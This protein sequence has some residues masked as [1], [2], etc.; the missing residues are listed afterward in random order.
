[1]HGIDPTLEL[2]V[3]G[4]AEPFAEARRDVAAPGAWHALAD[5]SDVQADHRA[6]PLGDDLG[7][8]FVG[9][10]RGDEQLHVHVL[11]RRGSHDRDLGVAEPMRGSG[12]G[13]RCDDVDRGDLLVEQEAGDVHLVDE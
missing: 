12:I 10:P 7:A 11:A 9:H 4:L 6:A 1:M 5:Q 2:R 3:V 13:L 8:D